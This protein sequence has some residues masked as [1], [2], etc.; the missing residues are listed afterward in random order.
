[1][2]PAKRSQLLAQRILEEEVVVALDSPGY[3]QPVQQVARVLS[4]SATVPLWRSL[5][6]LALQERDLCS[7]DPSKFN[8]RMTMAPTFPH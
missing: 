2:F 5:R 1:M 7:F 8:S 3:Q 4:S 6:L